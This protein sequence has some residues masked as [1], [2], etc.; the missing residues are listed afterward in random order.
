MGSGQWRNTRRTG[1]TVSSGAPLLPFSG[2]ASSVSGANTSSDA[3]NNH[4]GEPGMAS[5]PPLVCWFAAWS[6]IACVSSSSIFCPSSAHPRAMKVLQGSPLLA[7]GPFSLMVLWWWELSKG[8]GGGRDIRGDKPVRYCTYLQMAAT[9]TTLGLGFCLS[10]V[11]LSLFQ[12]D[13]YWSL[14][15]PSPVISNFRASV[16]LSQSDFS[17][18]VAAQKRQMVN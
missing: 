10:P 3:T 15:S 14:I 17:G 12:M 6:L 16:P 5:P 9:N 1:A 8:G 4:K 13:Q 7:G 11:F 2:Q 18:V